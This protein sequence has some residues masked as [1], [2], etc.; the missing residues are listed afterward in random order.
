MY[1]RELEFNLTGEE[2]ERLIRY[3]DAHKQSHG[4]LP[5]ITG[6]RFQGDPKPIVK[7]FRLVGYD[8]PDV[9]TEWGYRE[10]RNAMVELLE[11]RA[12]VASLSTQ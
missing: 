9:K 3:L 1:D 8:G 7:D 11:L 12:L 6:Y 5:L 10:I 2:I 4:N